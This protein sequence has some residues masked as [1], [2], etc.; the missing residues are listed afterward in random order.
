MVLLLVVGVEDGDTPVNPKTVLVQEL[1][2]AITEAREFCK[3]KG[4]DFDKLRT[5]QDA[6]ERA[7]VWDEAV[8]A[9]VV[10][11]EVEKALFC[12]HS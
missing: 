3:Q 11:E 2:E 7:K 10:S 12:S 8:E 9:V 5:T 6:F 4:I 1:R